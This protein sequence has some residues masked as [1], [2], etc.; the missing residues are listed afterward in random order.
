MLIPSE[1]FV[2]NLDITV[3][4][5]LAGHPRPPSSQRYVFA[6]GRG[7]GATLQIPA[8]FRAGLGQERKFYTERGGVMEGGPRK[9]DEGRTHLQSR[10]ASAEKVVLR[11]H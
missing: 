4:D 7:K 2:P 6:E 3:T 10:G 8:E 1:T 5:T 9:V 11:L